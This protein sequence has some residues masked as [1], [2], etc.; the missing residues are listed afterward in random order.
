MQLVDTDTRQGGDV[1]SPR[2]YVDCDLINNSNS[3][4]RVTIHALVHRQSGT[5]QDQRLIDV[6]PG[7]HTETFEFGADLVETNATGE[8]R[9]LR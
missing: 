1:F 6:P 4:H 2:L 5:Q 9:L 8:C 3:S 7:R